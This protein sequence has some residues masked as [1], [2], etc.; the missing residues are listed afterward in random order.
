M[1]KKKKFKDLTIKEFVL[2]IA[3]EVDFISKST[4]VPPIMV[5][6]DLYRQK[7]VEYLQ[8]NLNKEVEL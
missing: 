1:K 8:K 7:I 6:N 5:L 2:Y 3:K 4:A